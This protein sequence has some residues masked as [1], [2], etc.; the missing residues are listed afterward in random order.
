MLLTIAKHRE[1]KALSEDLRSA[2]KGAKAKV[3]RYKAFPILVGNC[4]LL[5]KTIYKLIVWTFKQK[6]YLV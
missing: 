5:I 6:F 4:T 1:G 3:L 2:G